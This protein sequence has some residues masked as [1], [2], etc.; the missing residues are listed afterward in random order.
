MPSQSINITVC[1][2]TY[3][4]PELLRRTLRGLAAL[5]TGGC[6]D[7]SIVVVDNDRLESA[8]ACVSEFAAVHPLPVVYAVEP[9]QN[10]ALARNKAVEHAAGDYIAFID[11]DEI[12]TSQWLLK[13]WQAIQK[14]GVDG[15]LGPVK[16]EYAVSTP[17][18]VMR[19]G[20]YDRPSYPT[21]TIIDW[22]KGRTGNVLLKRQVFDSEMPAFRPEFLSGEDQDFFQRVIQRGFRFVWCHEALAHEVVP[23]QRWSRWFM[24]RRALLRGSVSP[25]HASFGLRD[26]FKS[27]V[28]VVLYPLALPFM[29]FAGAGQCTLLLVKLFDHLGKL[30][31]LLG[32][33]PVRQ[34]YVVD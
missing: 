4:R 10:I 28:A 30:L 7:Y 8:R 21:G 5:D 23:P 20:F 33:R 32:I 13:L 2:C 16:P 25:R 29:I 26:I 1:V 31:A 6:F 15:A 17:A 34:P 19:G 24:L 11:D 3:R 18:W 12:P 27:I 14:Y 22:R 9:R